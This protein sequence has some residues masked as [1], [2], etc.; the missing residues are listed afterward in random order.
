MDPPNFTEAWDN[1]PFS[2]FIPGK[3]L[4][5][6]IA[7]LGRRPGAGRGGG[8]EGPNLAE[9][10]Q[11]WNSDLTERRIIPLWQSAGYLSR[12]SLL[13]GRS[14]V[15]SDGSFSAAGAAMQMFCA[16]ET[17]ARR[18][19]IQLHGHRADMRL[20]SSSGGRLIMKLRHEWKPNCSCWIIDECIYLFIYLVLNKGCRLRII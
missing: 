5:I 8:G 9:A 15:L 4:W 3:S 19:Q 14:L 20:L 13:W 12:V 16:R 10:E 7:L 17:A 11:K 1:P 2:P 18:R 6:L